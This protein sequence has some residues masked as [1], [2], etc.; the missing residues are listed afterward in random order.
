MAAAQG[1]TAAPDTGPRRGDA[2]KGALKT[3]GMARIC[4]VPVKGARQNSSPKQFIFL[5]WI[6]LG[7]NAQNKSSHR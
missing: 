1:N 7:K 6:V 2:A 4:A 3:T 5:A